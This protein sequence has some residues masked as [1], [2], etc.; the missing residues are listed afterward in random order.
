MKRLA[1]KL[2]AV[3]PA[4]PGQLQREGR[5]LHRLGSLIDSVFAIVI[6]V[7][8]LDLPEPDESIA[9]DLASFIAFQVDSLVVAML[10]IIVV[11]VYWFQSNLLLG[12]L[13]RTDGA[14]AA[15][16]LLQ[17]FLVLTYLLFVS[18]G[19]EFGNEPLVL[20]AQSVSATLVGFAAAAAWWYASYNRR[21]LTPEIGRRG[22]FVIW[23]RSADQYFR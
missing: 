19:I 20:A 5:E 11:L 2:F 17:I 10:G 7:M 15:I 6:V 4:G 13:H 1:S 18:L 14:H 9:F 21:L 8:V 12:N 22:R 16:S 23:L 3:K